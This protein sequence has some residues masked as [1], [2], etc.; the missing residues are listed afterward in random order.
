MIRNIYSPCCGRVEKVF[1]H[2]S[3]YVH[4]WEKLLLIR[5]GDG[6]INE[7]GVG[8]S[9]DIASLEVTEGEQVS[10]LTLLVKLHDDFQPTGSD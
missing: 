3:T 4:E 9:G 2:K 6:L 7:V 5:T 8:M 10:Y 1:V